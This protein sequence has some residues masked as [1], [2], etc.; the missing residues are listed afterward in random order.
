MKLRARMRGFE[1]SDD[2]AHFLIHRLSRQMQTLFQALDELD[3]ASIREK[4][5]LDST[6]VKENLS[7]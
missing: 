1:L 6:L 7:L 4:K 2:V 5:T 3:Q